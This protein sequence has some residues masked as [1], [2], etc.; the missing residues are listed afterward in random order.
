[1]R[2]ATASRWVTIYWSIIWLLTLVNLNT[3]LVGFHPHH[4]GLMLST[5][6]LLKASLLS[7][8][9]YPFN[10]YGSFWA[11]PYLV[12]SLVTP[13]SLLL[14]SMRLATMIL[15]LITGL[16]TYRIA[17]ILYGP[18]VAK[19]A[20]ITLVLSRPLGLEPIP[21]PSSIGM[22]LTVAITYLLIITLN[23]K[24]SLRRN[25]LIALVGAL[26][27]MSILTRIQIGAL[28]LSFICA[29]FIYTKR[30]DLLPF[31]FGFS[32]FS[33]LYSLW[34]GS[35]GW[36]RDSLEDQFVFG[37]FVA[38][39]GDTDR[40]FPKTSL[41][42]LFSL[43]F[44][45]AVLKKNQ[46]L[47]KA[48]NVGPWIFLIVVCAGSIYAFF[49]PSSF[50]V[51]L[52]K[53]WVAFLLFAIGLFVLNLKDILRKR[54]HQVLLVGLMSLAN[55]SQVFPLFDSMHAWWGLT[56]LVVLVSKWV[57]DFLAPLFGKRTR[58]FAL[59]GLSLVLTFPYVL[60]AAS[61]GGASMNTEDLG[62]IYSS[63]QQAN[64]YAEKR[65]F[66]SNNI[67]QNT[68]VLN[69]CGDSDLFF[70]SKRVMSASRYF[71][72]WPTMNA[73][74]RIQEE[75]LASKPEYVLFCDSVGS[76]IPEKLKVNFTTNPY[77]PLASL[78]AEGSLIL[79]TLAE[80]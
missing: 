32:T 21:W 11:M 29:Y 62:L 67:P 33:I 50:Q 41:V 19:V 55:A 46:K 30:H 56:P 20:L 1:M 27:I 49:D 34:L 66:F 17:K 3:V 31:A 64:D 71:V 28:T 57:V 36:L 80:N 76:G 15:Y 74:E 13:D 35:L 45:I 61:Q 39:S 12:I 38:S 75:I 58:A 54:Q 18:V 9:S 7:D 10:Q 42:I 44:F 65:D 73:S 6:R 26:T 40:T 51:Y 68:S 70:D 8:G 53:F 79:Y 77:K 48:L 2:F 14:F 4:D 52:G 5:I 69:L 25:L 59:F 63:S 16:L 37:W 23:L 24:H 78:G 22:F 43:V 60:I 47:A 72:Y